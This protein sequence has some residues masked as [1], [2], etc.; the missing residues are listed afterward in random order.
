MI[1]ILIFSNDLYS[2]FFRSSSII[3]LL[4]SF[5]YFIYNNLLLLYNYVINLF[6]KE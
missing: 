1:G 2:Q 4:I 6:F 5:L 3:N